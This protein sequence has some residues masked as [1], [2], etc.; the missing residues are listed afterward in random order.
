M[1]SAWLCT[2][3]YFTS[4]LA[5]ANSHSLFTS[6]SVLS[7]TF[8]ASVQDAQAWSLVW[9]WSFMNV[10]QVF[11]EPLMGGTHCSAM[12]I[13][14]DRKRYS[15]QPCTCS[16]SR[17]TLLFMPHSLSLISINPSFYISLRPRYSFDYLLLSK[18]TACFSWHQFYHPWM[19]VIIS[20]LIL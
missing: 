17:Q 16:W 4:S 15:P 14:G 12:Q 2:C 19:D 7:Y 8:S 9:A 11:R 6:T 5:S 1:F 20:K 3:N 18:P 10:S 13:P